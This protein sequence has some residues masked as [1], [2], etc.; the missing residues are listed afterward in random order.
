[1]TWRAVAVGLYRAHGEEDGE[2]HTNT[3]REPRLQRPRSWAAR[4]QNQRCERSHTSTRFVGCSLG[5]SEGC[6][7]GARAGKA[8][9]GERR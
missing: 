8:A 6:W 9:A 3:P 7:F 5:G 2:R 1:M 4:G